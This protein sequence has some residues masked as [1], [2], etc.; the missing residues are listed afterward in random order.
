VRVVRAVE[1]F[2]DRLRPAQQIA[3]QFWFHGNLAS[4]GVAYGLR[5][6]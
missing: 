5:L 4:M 3:R 6:P 2:A 1:H